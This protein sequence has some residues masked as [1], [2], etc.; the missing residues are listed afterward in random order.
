MDTIYWKS[1]EG[2]G[3][4]HHILG[5]YEEAIIYHKKVHTQNCAVAIIIMIKSPTDVGF[6]FVEGCE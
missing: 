1:I 5:N 2:L 6:F 3:N 4:V